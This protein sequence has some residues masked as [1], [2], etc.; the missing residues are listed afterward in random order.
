MIREEGV[1]VGWKEIVME[2]E[3]EGEEGKIFM[4]Q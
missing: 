1:G 4:R 2:K 3:D